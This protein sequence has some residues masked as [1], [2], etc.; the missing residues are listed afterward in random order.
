MLPQRLARL[1]H[2]QPLI[3]VGVAAVLFVSAGASSADASCGDYV[4]VRGL[5]ILSP[6]DVA[7]GQLFGQST[8]MDNRSPAKPPCQGPICSRHSDPVA[9]VP[10][11]PV[12]QNRSQDGAVLACLAMSAQLNWSAPLAE[13]DLLMPSAFRAEILHPPRF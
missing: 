4:H 2:V 1:F 6:A 12:P 13:S 10:P 3:A 5:H 11:A 9:P 7:L 8:G